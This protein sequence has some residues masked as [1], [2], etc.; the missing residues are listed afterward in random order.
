MKL[1]QELR[2]MIYKFALIQHERLII[3]TP[4]SYRLPLKDRRSWHEPGLLHASKQL[5]REAKAIHYLCHAIEIR[6]EYCEI[7]QV[8]LRL[9][10]LSEQLDVLWP[11]FTIDTTVA[12]C[13]SMVD[14]FSRAKLAYE[15]DFTVE[16]LDDGLPVELSRGLYIAP[17]RMA[18]KEV[19]QLGAYA[20][21]YRQLFSADSQAKEA[22]EVAIGPNVDGTGVSSFLERLAARIRRLAMLQRKKKTLSPSERLLADYCN[23]GLNTKVLR[24]AG[25]H[26][27]SKSLRALR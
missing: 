3:Q 9:K 25:L 17:V 26:A 5:H 19:V 21:Q 6:I 22:G 16:Q 18:L 15:S 1:P 23:W 11:A 7:T 20:K 4:D 12:R 8:Y 24:D 10:R 14:L 13:I 2:D 27:S